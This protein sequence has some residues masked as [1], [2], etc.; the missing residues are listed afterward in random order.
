M[1]AYHLAGPVLA[2]FLLASPAAAQTL[3]PGLTRAAQC[4]GII[5]GASSVGFA[6]GAEESAVETDFYIANTYLFG[7]SKKALGSDPDEDEFLVYDQIHSSMIDQVI[8]IY[9][10]GQWGLQSLSDV[11]IC[12]TEASTFFI[13]EL[14]NHGV[15]EDKIRK[16]AAD[17]VANV[18]ILFGLN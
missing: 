5:K 4:A 2:A 15:N 12:Y 14:P 10:A 6:L 1:R 9:N 18:K 17:Q 11:I 7:A 16:L 3:D 13:D 8:G